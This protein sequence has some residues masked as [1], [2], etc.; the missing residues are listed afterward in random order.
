MEN[1]LSY[2]RLRINLKLETEMVSTKELI[3]I[4]TISGGTG[5]VE[6]KFSTA[7]LKKFNGLVEVLTPVPNIN[8]EIRL[9]R[10][11]KNAKMNFANGMSKLHK[12][13]V[14]DILEQFKQEM[15]LKLDFFI[16]FSPLDLKKLPIYKSVRTG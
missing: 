2:N 12:K 9:E 11:I 4:I 16:N 6:I 5:N 13:G 10:A 7:L 8:R 1:I 3:K 14:I 15:N